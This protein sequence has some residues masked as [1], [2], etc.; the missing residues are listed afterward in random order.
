MERSTD[1]VLQLSRFASITMLVTYVA[2]LAYQ[3]KTHAHLYEDEPDPAEHAGITL[4]PNEQPQHI[5]VIHPVPVRP[6]SVDVERGAIQ[7]DSENNS[8]VS[9]DEDDE[10]VPI[11][12]FWGS[13]GARFGEIVQSITQFTFNRHMLALLRHCAVAMLIVTVV[14]SV[15]SD[16]LVKAIEGAAKSWNISNVFIGVIIIPIAGNAAE[17]ASAVIFAMKNRMEIS[18]GVAIGSSIQIAVF[19]IPL[20]VVIGWSMGKR[21]SLDFQLF[22]TAVIFLAVVMTS[23]MIQKGQSSWLSGLMLIVAYLIIGCAFFVHKDDDEAVTG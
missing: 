14:I 10:E 4:P 20:L 5:R 2:F 17:H 9:R 23:I 21:M 8:L 22:E 7:L 19:V 13:I 3:L 11:L 15:L 12:G 6:T 16:Y 1:S 18:I